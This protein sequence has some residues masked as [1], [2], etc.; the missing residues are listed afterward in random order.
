MS[1]PS[2][3]RVAMIS[4]AG[5]YAG[6]ALARLLAGR[7]H[8]LVLGDP[9]PALVD[10]LRAVGS[11]VAVVDDVADLATDGATERLVDAARER[12]GRLDAATM[13]SGVIVTGRFA[14]ATV[15][16]LHLAVR[17]CMEAPFRFLKAVVPAMVDAGGGQ[18]LVQTSAAG[19][20][21]TPGAPLYSAAR[22]GANHLVRNVAGE[23]ARHGVQVNAVGTNF[24]DFPAFLKASG[25]ETPEGRERVEA[26]VPMRRLGALEEF[27]AFCAVF[28]DGTSGFTTGQFVPYAG[29]WA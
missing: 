28:L 7:G 19:A 27:A 16:D 24:M 9:T 21:T 23:V 25:A 8:D 26:M 17:G 6:P 15:D 10:E 29:G 11:E 20:R 14:D 18:V 12:F 13:A 2:P 5:T 4:A 3:R 1:D 22:A